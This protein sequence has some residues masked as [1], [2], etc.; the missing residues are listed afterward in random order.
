VSRARGASVADRRPGA[1]RRAGLTLFELLVTFSLFAI[2]LTLT[3]FFYGQSVKATRRHDQGSEVYR[4]A[5]NLFSDIERFLH[6]GILMWAS[7]HQ[8]VVSVFSE[9]EAITDSRLFAFTPRAHALTLSENGLRLQVA[10]E[11]EREFSKLKSWEGLSFEP[12]QFGL[13]DPQRR[14]DYVTLLYTAMPPSETRDKR[15]YHFK[16]QVLL[17]RY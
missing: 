5:H 3:L 1:G 10:E 6:S 4:R 7:D 8:L 17:V 11:P 14:Y 9:E 12:Q 13:G 2:I 15:P 16:R